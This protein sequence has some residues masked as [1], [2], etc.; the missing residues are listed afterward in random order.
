MFW[1][2]D[3]IRDLPG[4]SFLRVV[5]C[6]SAFGTTVHEFFGC[7][8]GSTFRTSN[9][10]KKFAAVFAEYVF[11]RNFIATE[12]AEKLGFLFCHIILLR[13]LFTVGTGGAGLR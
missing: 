1:K 9:C 3:G 8:G 12:I 2:Y 10:S 4:I 11:L 7:T 6:I 13:T 5:E